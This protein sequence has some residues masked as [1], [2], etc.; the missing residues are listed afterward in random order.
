MTIFSTILTNLS[1]AKERLIDTRD[2]LLNCQKLLH[3][4]REELKKLW[5]EIIENRAVFNL[6]ERIERVSALPKQT[7]RM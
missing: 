4:K 7:I 5:L 1:K 3:C 2:K 6:L